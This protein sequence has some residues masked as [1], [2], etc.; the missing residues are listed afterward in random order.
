M[1]TQNKSVDE[2]IRREHA[3]ESSRWAMYVRIRDHNIHI[4]TRFVKTQ[5]DLL[6]YTSLAGRFESGLFAANLPPGG[7]ESKRHT[8]CTVYGRRSI[9]FPGDVSFF[10]YAE[11]ESDFIYIN[12]PQI[13]VDSEGVRWI[14]G[15]T[16]RL[17]YQRELPKE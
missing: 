11:P 4:D 1:Q 12:I 10:A 5:E 2:I 13:K 16:G 6:K 17:M 9:D 3:I 8:G 7:V 14:S 15:N